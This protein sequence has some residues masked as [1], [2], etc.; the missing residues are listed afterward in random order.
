MAG[1]RRVARM[2][3]RYFVPLYFLAVLVQVFLAGYGVFGAEDETIEKADTLD[4]HRALGFIISHAVGLLLLIVA[5]LAW[6]PNK[7]LRWMSI[8]GPVLLFLQ[9]FLTEGRWAGAFH[10]VNAF[11][12]LGL[13]GYLAHR[14]WRGAD[15]SDLTETRAAARGI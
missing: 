3:L 7:R 10:P 15:A 6:L 4:P 12:I 14:L 8:A 9:P 2:I 13:L 11:L 1:V 5:A